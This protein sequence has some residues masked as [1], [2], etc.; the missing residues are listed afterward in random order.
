MDLLLLLLLPAVPVRYGIPTFSEFDV[1]VPLH[2]NH[3]GIANSPR[4]D[5]LHYCHPGVPEVSAEQDH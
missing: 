2:S 3:V 5:C 4:T 1:S